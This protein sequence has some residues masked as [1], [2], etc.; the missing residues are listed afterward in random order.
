M[1]TY[2]YTC[3]KCGEFEAEHKMSDPPLTECPKEECKG[4]VQRLISKGPGFLLVG[5]GWYKD[6]Y[7]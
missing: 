7:R 2:E 1:P 4:K 6:G 5:S 3:E